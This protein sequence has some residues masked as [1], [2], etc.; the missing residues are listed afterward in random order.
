MSL[1]IDDESNELT[2][3]EL[4]IAILN[5]LQILNMHMTEVTDIG[6]TEEDVDDG[7]NL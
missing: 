2:T 1:I 3:N 4:L 6:F 7:Y 5:E